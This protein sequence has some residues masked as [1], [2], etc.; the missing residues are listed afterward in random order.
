[1]NTQ[2]LIARRV[3]SVWG[4]PHLPNRLR[5]FPYSTAAAL[6]RTTP[7]CCFAVTAW[8]APSSAAPVCTATSFWPLSG[9]RSVRR[10]PGEYSGYRGITQPERVLMMKPSVDQLRTEAQINRREYS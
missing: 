7:R 3:S 9:L 6:S 8:T 5:S 10:T 1:M 2:A 4:I